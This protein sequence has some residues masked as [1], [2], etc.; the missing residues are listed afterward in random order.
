LNDQQQPLTERDTARLLVAPVMKP[1]ALVAPLYRDAGRTVHRGATY[2][3]PVVLERLEGFEGEVTLQLASR[4]DRIRQGIRGDDIVVPPDQTSAE[5]PLFLPEWVQTDRTSRIILNTLVK[6]PDPQG[7]L[8]Y[9]LNKMDKRIT[10]NVEGAL[11]KITADRTELPAREGDTVKIPLS[12]S[13]S[14]KLAGPAKLE[15]VDPPA[16]SDL[17]APLTLSADQTKATLQL[18]CP[19]LPASGE[20][21]ITI[22]AIV[23][24]RADLPVISRVEVVLVNQLPQPAARATSAR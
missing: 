7:N 21:R 23:R 1:R 3:A 12:V 13:R 24:P 17:T 9:L 22:R 14:P 16:W 10:M 15:I 20:Q 2:A 5:F 8:R 18:E 4:P 19:P 6:V 11:L